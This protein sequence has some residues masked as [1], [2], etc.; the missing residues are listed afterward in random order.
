MTQLCLCKFSA[1]LRSFLWLFQPLHVK[2]AFFS[3]LAISQSWLCQ[4]RKRSHSRV[5]AFKVSRL[6]YRWNTLELQSAHL[7]NDCSPPQL[8]WSGFLPKQGQLNHRYCPQLWTKRQAYKYGI[9]NS[10]TDPLLSPNIATV[11]CPVCQVYAPIFSGKSTFAT[12]FATHTSD[13]S[14]CNQVSVFISASFFLAVC[15][16]H[17]S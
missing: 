17:V 16:H 13:H 10:S 3:F 1:P 7:Q 6:F 12:F 11:H 4:H 14:Y 9:H 15:P 2:L 5:W 8:G